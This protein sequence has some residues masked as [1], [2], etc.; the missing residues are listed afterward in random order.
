MYDILNVEACS[1]QKTSHI[2][3]GRG[4]DYGG[5]EQKRTKKEQRVQRK[6][7]SHSGEGAKNEEGSE[8]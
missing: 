2:L 4:A 7:A 6:G 1:W 5:K 3:I 8:G